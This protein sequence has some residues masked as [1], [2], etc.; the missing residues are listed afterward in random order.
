MCA[1]CQ[2]CPLPDDKIVIYGGE[3]SHRRPLAEAYVLDLQEFSWSKIQ[4]TSKQQPV[5]RSGHAATLVNNL[6][7]VFGGE[8]RGM[9]CCWLLYIFIVLKVVQIA[10]LIAGIG[11]PAAGCPCCLG[12]RSDVVGPSCLL[13][14]VSLPLHD[15]SC[16]RKR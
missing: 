2:A 13:P 14:L 9:G 7:V 5:A 16:P 15:P 10:A 8:R 11:G 4:V 12:K 6:L 1:V 3:D